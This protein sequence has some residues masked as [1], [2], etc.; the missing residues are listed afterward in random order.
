VKTFVYRL[1]P[2]KSQARL[3]ASTVETCRRVYN[4]CLA[5]RKEAWE[6]ERR[7]V[8]KV[9]QLRHVKTI[10]ATNPHAKTIHS[11]VLQVTVADL[12]KAFTA[13]FRRV[14]VGEMPGYPRFKG[15]NRFDSFGLKRI[16]QRLEAR[17]PP[18]APV[19]YRPGCRSLASTTRRDPQ[20]GPHPV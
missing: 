6:Q 9:E 18:L 12:D 4:D 10:K 2:S 5:E 8:T 1:Y 7:T 19:R 20:D 15:R 16:R 17:W 13:F 14:K 11:H 3:L